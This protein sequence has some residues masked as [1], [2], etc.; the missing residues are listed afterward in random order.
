MVY[1][2]PGLYA[3][4]RIRIPSFRRRKTNP[5]P[6]LQKYSSTSYFQCLFNIPLE[7]VEI[8][9]YFICSFNK[10][11]TSI[12]YESG[13][14]SLDLIRRR[15]LIKFGSEIPHRPDPIKKNTWIRHTMVICGAGGI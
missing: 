10:E 2:G 9:I 13:S 14:G 5:D 8:L 11:K 3:G 15:P 7:K 4:L 1:K 12:R 6:N